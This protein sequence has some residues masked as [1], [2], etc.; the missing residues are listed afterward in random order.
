MTRTKVSLAI[1]LL[2]PKLNRLISNNP[3][4]TG[5]YYQTPFAISYK[6]MYNAKKPNTPLRIMDYAYGTTHRFIELHLIV[7]ESNA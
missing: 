5:V 7:I 4:S 3:K 1:I 6:N 2:L